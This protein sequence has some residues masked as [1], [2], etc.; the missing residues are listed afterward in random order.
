MCEWI[1]DLEQHNVPPRLLMLRGMAGTLL[2]LRR[3]PPDPIK[4]GKY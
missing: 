4:V 3:S 1:V 2:A